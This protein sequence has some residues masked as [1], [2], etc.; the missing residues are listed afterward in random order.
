MTR[1]VWA[2][3]FAIA[4]CGDDDT[5]PAGSGGSG[6][7]GGTG[8]SGEDCLDPLPEACDLAFAPTY[9]AFYD[10]LLSRTCGASS[11]G[12]SCHGPDGGMAGLYLHDREMAYDYLLGAVDDRARVIPGD[13]ECSVLVHRIE[14]TD[15][16]FLMPP[17]ARLSDGERCAIERWI[18]T[19]A[20]R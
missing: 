14:S 6:G 9:D 7:N 12:S 15:P 10:N 18:A 8:G 20:K 11:T 4:A 16:D 17:T 5:N 13:P 19:G 3:A 2:V 1:W